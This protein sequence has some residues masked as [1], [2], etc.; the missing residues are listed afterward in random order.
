MD[1]LVYYTLL[2]DMY[3]GLLTEK[4]KLYFEK[5]YFENLSLQELAERYEISRNAI[6]KQ[7]KEVITKLE[8]YEDVLQLVAKNKQL[9]QFLEKLPT[10][11]LKY[12][13]R[14]IIEQ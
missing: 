12:Q 13:L 8:H 11:N 9:E 6:H 5:Y 14:S 2:F 1:K 7:V 4:Q 3:Q 10:E